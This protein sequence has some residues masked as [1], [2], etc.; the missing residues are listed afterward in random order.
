MSETPPPPPSPD[1]PDEPPTTQAPTSPRRLLRSRDDRV[2]GGVCG[3]LARYFNVDPL[4]IRIAA[5]A[6][7]FV[8]GVSAIAYVAA[9]LLVPD[10]DG[11]GHPAP[12]RPGRLSTIVGAAVVILAGVALLDGHWGFGFGWFFGALA[13]AL[14]IVMILAIAGQRLLINRG[15]QQP[16]A[17]RIAG[18]ALLLT[19]ITLGVFVLAAGGAVATAAGGGAAI[20]GVVIVLGLLMVALSFKDP[21]A[22]WLALPALA[23]AIPAGV[24]A[25]A[26]IDVDHGVGSRHYAPATVADLRSSGY[27]LGVGEL[28][29]DLRDMQWPRGTTVDLKVDVGTGHALVLVPEDVCVEADT[30]AGLGYVNLLGEDDGGADVDEQRGTVRRTAGRRLV[31]DADMGIGAIEVRHNDAGNH[32]GRHW[33]PH[34]DGP[35]AISSTLADAGCA[36][37][38]A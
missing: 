4:I 27:E 10:D 14:L 34:D 21:R 3:G 22:R 37:E 17:A 20:A 36:G 30:H 7:L 13:P 12:G 31:L 19:G 16:P 29:V 5:V 24:V 25:A 32:D 18:A 9:L 28:R 38:R 8:G 11:T 6:L 23:L 26:G 1:A 33:G 15:E 2:I 35:D